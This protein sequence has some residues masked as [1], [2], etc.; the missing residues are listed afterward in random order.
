MY[1]L[2]ETQTDPKTGEISMY[3]DLGHFVQ[4]LPDFRLLLLYQGVKLYR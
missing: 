3:Y 4:R 1:D 2:F